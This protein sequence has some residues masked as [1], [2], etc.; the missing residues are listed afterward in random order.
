MTVN[1]RMPVWRATD[2]HVF[3]AKLLIVIVSTLNKLYGKG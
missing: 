1:Y 2:G 3:V